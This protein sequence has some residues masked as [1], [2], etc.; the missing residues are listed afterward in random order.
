M[1]QL[2]RSPHR[3]LVLFS[4]IAM[5]LV[6]TIIVV[7]NKMKLPTPIAIDTTDQPTLGYQ[8]AL[9]RVVVFEEPKCSD[10]RD[11]TNTIFP[12]IKAEFIDTNKILYT[13]IPVSFLPDS[14]PVACALLCTYYH[15]HCY[16][17]AEM[18]FAFLDYIYK[19][20]PPEHT[21]WA[22]VPRI[23]ELAKEASPAIDITWLGDCT[24]QQ[25][26]RNQVVRNTE[27]AKSIMGGTVST[28]TVYVDGM[29]LDT[30][31]LG[32]LR[33]LIKAAL[34]LKGIP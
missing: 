1:D 26:Y 22:S 20:Q 27:Y 33:Y 21:D 14:M 11:Y 24:T 7:T 12:Q 17:N 29:K 9:I 10:C 16:P 34:E 18:F 3:L 15:P 2:T 28:P 4:L 25:T 32:D 5:A 6:A 19:H 8:K 23:L 31:T 13:V 30:L